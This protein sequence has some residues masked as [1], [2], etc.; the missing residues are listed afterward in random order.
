[1]T[2]LLILLALLV[3]ERVFTHADTVEAELARKILWPD[4]TTGS[5]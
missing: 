3:A 2:A 4:L 5:K 1:M